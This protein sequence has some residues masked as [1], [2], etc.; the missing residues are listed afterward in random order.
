M[1]NSLNDELIANFMCVPYIDGYWRFTKETAPQHSSFLWSSLQYKNDW[2]WLMPVVEK[3]E[4]LGYYPQI[5][6][7]EDG[8]EMIIYDEML[9]YNRKMLNVIIPNE[10]VPNTFKKINVVYNTVVK[11]IR[12]Y[13][14]QE[15]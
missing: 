1:E 2:N 6:T 14:S 5:L 3:I 8:Q 4:S 9:S 7:G 12:W 11:F 10:P 13:N 15:K